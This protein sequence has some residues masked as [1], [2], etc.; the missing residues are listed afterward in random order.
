[1]ICFILSLSLSQEAEAELTG[2]DGV[3]KVDYFI[4]WARKGQKDI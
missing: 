2:R 3:K 1:M 4:L